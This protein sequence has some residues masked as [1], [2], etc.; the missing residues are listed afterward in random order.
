[1]R[2][3]TVIS[4]IILLAFTSSCKYFK[5]KKLF[6]H[7]KDDVIAAWQLKQDSLR[8]ADSIKAV[9]LRLQAAENTRLDSI[10]LVEEKKVLEQKN[11]YNLIVGSFITPEYAR[12]LADV[13]RQKGYETNIIR[14]E[15]SRFELVSAESFDDIHKAFTRLKHYQDNEEPNAW[16]Y[17]KR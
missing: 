6:G 3:L 8:V 11:K 12:G 1:M 13:Y 9:E 2:H 7:K 17:K 5:G 16:I 10:R 14:M 4:L 15:G